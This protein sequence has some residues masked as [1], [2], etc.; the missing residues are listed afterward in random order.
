[1]AKV[2]AQGTG[3]KS[4]RNI[5]EDPAI[6]AAGR[7]DPI[8]R[9]LVTNW[10]R[11]VTVLVAIGLGFVAYNAFTVTNNQKRASATEL[12]NSIRDQYSEIVS[13][14]EELISLK[15]EQAISGPEPKTDAEKASSVTRIAELT[16]EVDGMRSKAKLMIASLDSPKPFDTL[17]RL[18]GGLLASRFGDFESAKSALVGTNWE[19]AGRPESAERLV[20]EMATLGLAK[21]LLDSEQFVATG[22]EYLWGLA[23][24][25]ETAAVPAASSLAAAVDS[26]EDKTKIRTTLATLKKRFPTQEKYL[27]EAAEKIAP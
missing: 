26:A 21:S 15:A 10:K 6:A 14:Q 16:K 3:S 24:R 7:D 5:F 13:K 1:M 23:D 17:A 18:Y 22:R 20:A 4:G 9:F 25:G 19:I 27:T 2:T 11:M 8:A 12:F